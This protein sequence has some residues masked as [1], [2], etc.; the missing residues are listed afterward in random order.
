MAWFRNSNTAF[1]WSSFPW[2]TVATSYFSPSGIILEME[3]HT[4]REAEIH[5]PRFSIHRQKLDVWQSIIQGTE[6]DK[7]QKA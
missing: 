7:Q 5:S 1:L 6:V 2:I 3:I 4:A